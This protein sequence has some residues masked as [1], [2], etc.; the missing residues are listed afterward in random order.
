[1]KNRRISRRRFLFRSPSTALAVA[2]A[3]AVL[4]PENTLAAHQVSV[5]SQPEAHCI[6]HDDLP[7]NIMQGAPPPKDKRVTVANYRENQANRRWVHQH[8]REI[9]PTQN[10][11]RG[12][13]PRHCP[14]DSMY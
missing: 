2:A 11:F 5:C 13:G 10:I 3:S 14:S 6:I 7:S 8:M 4:I 9:F 12:R 1:M